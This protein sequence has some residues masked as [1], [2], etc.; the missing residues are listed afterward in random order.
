MSA[1]HTEDERRRAAV[2]E[3]KRVFEILQ[4][5]T[6]LGGHGPCVDTPDPAEVLQVDQLSQIIRSRLPGNAVRHEQKRGVLALLVDDSRD[7]AEDVGLFAAGGTVGFRF[8]Q[9]LGL[10]FVRDRNVRL[11]GLTRFTDKP[12]SHVVVALAEDTFDDLLGEVLQDATTDLALDRAAT[13]ALEPF[14]HNVNPAD[15]TFHELSDLGE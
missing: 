6:E 3:V 1:F 12:A 5:S 10:L 4:V 7:V 8:D 11:L 15:W 2:S 9:D 13:A 14:D